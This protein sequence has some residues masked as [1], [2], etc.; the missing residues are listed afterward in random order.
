MTDQTLSARELLLR[1]ASATEG[2]IETGANRG[3]F[4]DRCNALTGAPPGSPWCASWVAM[5]GATAFGEKWPLPKTAGCATLGDFAKRKAML[6][7][8]PMRGDVFLVYFPKLNRYAHTGF[9]DTVVN[10]T[11]FT[12]IEGN[13]N[14]D[15]SREGW[16]VFRRTRT[17]GPHDRF[18][19]WS[20]L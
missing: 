8:A 1:V 14:N 2:A 5:C 16:G 11:S 6:S 13:T 20:L 17:I 10:S 18:I 9:V 7:E 15:G 4:V 12:T 3:P 19:R